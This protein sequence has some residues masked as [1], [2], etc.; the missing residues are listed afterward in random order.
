MISLPV[1][2]CHL[3][4]RANVIDACQSV[5]VLRQRQTIEQLRPSS[6]VFFPRSPTTGPVQVRDVAGHRAVLPPVLL[7][8]VLLARVQRSQ[9]PACGAPMGRAGV[10]LSQPGGRTARSR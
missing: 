10:Q 8:G 2:D 3:V 4:L 1:N 9:Q 6:N 5:A 7:P